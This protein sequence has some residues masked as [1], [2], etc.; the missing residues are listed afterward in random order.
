MVSLSDPQTQQKYYKRSPKHVYHSNK[1]QNT[2]LM[3]L[4][5]REDKKLRKKENVGGWINK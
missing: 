5:S 2:T 1:T 3:L 4:F